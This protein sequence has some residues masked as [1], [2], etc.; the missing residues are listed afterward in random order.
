MHLVH[1]NDNGMDGALFQSVFSLNVVGGLLYVEISAAG[2]AV[3]GQSSLHTYGRQLR[4]V[5]AVQIAGDK[6]DLAEKSDRRDSPFFLPSRS[7]ERTGEP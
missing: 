3:G 2:V 7:R 5:D 4:L 6:R 1:D